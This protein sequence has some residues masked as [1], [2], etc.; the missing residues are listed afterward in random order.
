MT[1]DRWKLT[2]YCSC[3]PSTTRGH[4]E[5]SSD[6]L[7]VWVVL[8]DHEAE[9]AARDQA[10]KDLGYQLGEAEQELAHLRAYQQ[11]MND[12]LKENDQLRGN[13][14]LAEEGLANYAQEI[15]GAKHDIDQ[16]QAAASAEANEAERLR[17]LLRSVQ[18]N[19]VVPD[20]LMADIEHAIG[21][22]K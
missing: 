7:A 21:P 15:E 2:S 1:V 8:S 19:A 5:K 22:A 10:L 13:L 11:Q 20:E 3:N 14:S 16:L 12:I 4:F 6:E 17:T 18:I 9:I